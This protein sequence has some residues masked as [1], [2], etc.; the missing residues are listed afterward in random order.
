M[1]ILETQ[2]RVK[3]PKRTNYAVFKRR[4]R[5]ALLFVALFVLVLISFGAY[6]FS[7][8]YEEAS[9]A[10]VEEV[11]TP[12]VEGAPEAP[13]AEEEAAEQQAAEEQRAAEEQAAREAE[14]ERRA[15]AGPGDPTL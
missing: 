2:K 10:P 7:G 5:N 15:T 6:L 13:S 9:E 3:D 1:P 14:A 8:G 12:A 4:R 11:E